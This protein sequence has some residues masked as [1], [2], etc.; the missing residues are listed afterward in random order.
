MSARSSS[1]ALPRTRRSAARTIQQMQVQVAASPR[2]SLLPPELAVRAASRTAHRRLVFAVVGVILVT[3]AGV[4]VSFALT[5]DAQRALDT[6]RL[7]T[8]SL[9]A[10]QKKYTEASDL[11]AQVASVTQ[12]RRYGTSTEIDWAAYLAQVTATLPAGSV[13][14]EASVSAPAPWEA[15]AVAAGPLRGDPAATLKLRVSSA[16]AADISTWV[17]SLE[18]LPGY[19]D[20]SLDD[21]SFDD[22]SSAG[23]SAD[24]SLDD[25]APTYVAGITLNITSAARAN[26]FAEN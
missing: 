24:S 22:D 4:G 9:I 21:R 20:S 26:R 13:L 6:A 11:E 25:A 12:A 14:L 16:S 2:V 7:E 1:A 8:T 3:A 19:A 15:G 23:S 5:A 18:A 17:R 10:Q